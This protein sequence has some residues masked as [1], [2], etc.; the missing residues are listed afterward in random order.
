[1]EKPRHGI[2]QTNWTV[3]GDVQ[4]RCDTLSGL[5]KTPEPSRLLWR[6]RDTVRFDW[7]LPQ[8]SSKQSTTRAEIKK[9]RTK[10]VFNTGCRKEI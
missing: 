10:C 7:G 4:S 9:L 6:R 2:R 1:M 5:W 3:V 8:V